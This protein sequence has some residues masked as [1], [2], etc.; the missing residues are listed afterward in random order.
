M[1]SAAAGKARPASCRR[2]RSAAGGAGSGSGVAMSRWLEPCSSASRRGEGP[3]GHPRDERAEP[4]G[5][6]GLS[7]GQRQGRAAAGAGD[8]LGRA[9]SDPDLGTVGALDLGEHPEQ[10]VGAGH[11]QESGV[12]GEPAV[13][14]A[15]A[16][17]AGGQARAGLRLQ[18]PAAVG[19]QRVAGEGL[20][21]QASVLLDSADQA[22]LVG[23]VLGDDPGGA[24]VAEGVD[25]VDGDAGVLLATLRLRSAQ[26]RDRMDQIQPLP[27]QGRVEDLL[28]TAAHAE[29]GAGEVEVV[30]RGEPPAAPALKPAPDAD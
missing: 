25:G 16:G 10:G 28:L 24:E 2:R 8:A 15:A 23:G 21:Q 27:P 7:A 5:D 4:A 29:D 1:S 18:R 12:G 30:D 19:A 26:V 11:R 20:Q 14:V 9:G 22:R 17:A 13:G 3:L 6:D